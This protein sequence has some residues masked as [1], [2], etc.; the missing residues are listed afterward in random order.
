MAL[1]AALARASKKANFLNTNKGGGHLGPTGRR[2]SRPPRPLHDGPLRTH[3]RHRLAD[4]GTP[5]ADKG[6][7]LP[8]APPTHALG[9]GRRRPRRAAQEQRDTRAMVNAIKLAPYSIKSV[10]QF[11]IYFE[12]KKETKS[13]FLT[14]TP[15][16]RWPSPPSASLGK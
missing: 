16:A 11:A 1:V 9:Q 2:S 4:T 10:K 8:Q 13:G 5:T 7:S 12:T 3:G 14:G 15:W 6:S